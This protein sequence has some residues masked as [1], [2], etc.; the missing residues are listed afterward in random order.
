MFA[1]IKTFKINRM[2]FSE[3]NYAINA[4]LAEVLVLFLKWLGKHNEWNECNLGWSIPRGN[5]ESWIFYLGNLATRHTEPKQLFFPFRFKKSYILRKDVDISFK[6]VPR[7]CCCCYDRPAYGNYPISDYGCPFGFRP[8][9]GRFFGTFVP[10]AI[11][12]WCCPS[13]NA[14]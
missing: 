4:S 1:P 2:L 7:C 11:S 3:A 6:G 13:P 10:W 9:S 8:R 14:A 5:F 12:S